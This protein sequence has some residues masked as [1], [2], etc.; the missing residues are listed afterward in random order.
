MITIIITDSM[1]QM[2]WSIGS[3]A[4]IIAVLELFGIIAITEKTKRAM[5]KLRNH[6]VKR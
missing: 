2:L 1:E 5:N 6:E 4:S 3:M